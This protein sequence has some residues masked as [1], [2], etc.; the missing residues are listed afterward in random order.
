MSS[1]LK[2]LTEEKV[3]HDLAK[4]EDMMRLCA[5]MLG[6]CAALDPSQAQHLTIG[7]FFKQYRQYNRDLVKQCVSYLSVI[8]PSPIMVGY[9]FFADGDDEGRIIPNEDVAKA[10]AS[11]Y[12]V[13]PV[14]GILV[15]EFEKKIFVFYRVSEDLFCDE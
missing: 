11:G 1:S 8:Q 13:D 4:N 14:S 15:E 5:N 3:H 2:K 6:D 9:E 7:Y 10:L 12:F